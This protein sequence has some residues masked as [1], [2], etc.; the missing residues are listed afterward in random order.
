VERLE[1]ERLEVERLE[2]ERLDVERE[3]AQDLPEQGWNLNPCAAPRATLTAG[4]SA[5]VT[6]A[7]SRDRRRRRR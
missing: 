7:S 4:W 2:V 3:V 6:P 5:S 1:V